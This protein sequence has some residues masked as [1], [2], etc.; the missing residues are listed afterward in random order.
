MFYA[1]EYLHKHVNLRVYSSMPLY[2]VH[3]LIILHLSL[4]HRPSVCNVECILGFLFDR[5]SSIACPVFKHIREMW[6]CIYG[7]KNNFI[8]MEN[9]TP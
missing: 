3:L 5:A 6:K 4:Q 8:C 1:S 2:L 7:V 9:V